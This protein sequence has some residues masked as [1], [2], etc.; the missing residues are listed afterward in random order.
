M[1]FKCGDGAILFPSYA[2]NPTARLP[3]YRCVRASSTASHLLLHP[4]KICNSMHHNIIIICAPACQSLPQ[5]PLPPPHLSRR[6][7]CRQRHVCQCA[8]CDAAEWQPRGRRRCSLAPGER[9]VDGSGRRVMVV[10]VEEEEGDGGGG[11]GEPRC[12]IRCRH[13]R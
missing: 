9:A 3:S 4:R 10:V 12:C 2:R 5:P 7:C 1:R 11:A 6:R 8:S 13:R